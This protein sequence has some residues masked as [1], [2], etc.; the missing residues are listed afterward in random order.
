MNIVTNKAR[1]LLIV[2]SMAAGGAER[3]TIGLF[4][5]LQKLHYDA[6]L[7]VTNWQEKKMRVYEVEHEDRVL[8]SGMHTN[9]HIR[10]I[11]NLIKLRKVINDI[12]PEVVISLGCSY[13]LMHAAG[14]FDKAKTVL[15]ERNWPPSYYQDNGERV[16]E[17]YKKATRVVFQTP[18]ARDCFPAINKSCVIPNPVP[19]S[20]VRWRGSESREIIYFGRLDKQKRPE[21][22]LRA[23]QV[24]LQT[25]RGYHLSYYGIGSERESLL[26]YI[27]DQGLSESVSINPPSRDIHRIA[28]KALLYL[29][30][31][32]YEGI[33]NSMLE[34]LSIGMPCVCTDCDGG[35]ARLAIHDGI[36][37]LLADK[38]DYKSIASAMSRIADSSALASTISEEALNRIRT[39]DSD[40]VFSKWSVLIDSVAASE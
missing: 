12:K 7:Y 3:V 4:E 32:D 26:A 6:W 11:A 22:A 23:F 37:G 27:A 17:Y 39:F 1:V 10:S 34:A 25:H 14:V 36:N 20:D 35:G 29:N 5:Y 30:T 13:R 2:N 38:G 21:L 33:S 18:D 19:R 9:S 16:N 15:S 8:Q 40:E 24:F 28:S 31:S